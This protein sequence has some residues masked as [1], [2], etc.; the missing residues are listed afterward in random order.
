MISDVKAIKVNRAITVKARD[1]GIGKDMEVTLARRHLNKRHMLQSTTDNHI[2]KR[3][4]S[5]SETLTR[6]HTHNKTDYLA[7][8]IAIHQ[9]RTISISVRFLSTTT[10]RWILVLRLPVR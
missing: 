5:S 3:H 9:T 8:A 4:T 2:T 7:I 10:T 1:K 6:T